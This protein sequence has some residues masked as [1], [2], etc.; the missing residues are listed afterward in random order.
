MSTGV[1]HFTLYYYYTMGMYLCSTHGP[2]VIGLALN[3]A[4]CISAMSFGKKDDGTD[5]PTLAKAIR[6]S[7]F[8]HMIQTLGDHP[9]INVRAPPPH[10][11]LK[12]LATN[13]TNQV[14][15]FSDSINFGHGKRAWALTDEKGL[16][17]LSNF[18]D[19]G[20][21][22]SW[23]EPKLNSCLLFVTPWFLR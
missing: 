16:F 21:I 11:P 12:S 22:K 17:D 9:D 23:C 7:T 8:H 5:G 18:D 19:G 1:V 6:A 10:S 4:H 20:P 14:I 2:Q 3:A 15:C 13:K